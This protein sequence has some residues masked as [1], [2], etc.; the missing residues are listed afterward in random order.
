M[1]KRIVKI[2]AGAFI[3]LALLTLVAYVATGPQDP[4]AD[5]SSADWLQAGPFRIASR[6]YRFVDESRPTAENRGVPSQP[7]RTLITTLWYPE[8][9]P[10]EMPLVVHSHGILSERTELDYLAES[11]AS[12]GYVV[13][14]ANYP[15]T[16]GEAVGG[17]NAVDVVN[18]PAD[19]SF[20]MDSIL[21]LEGND[22]PFEGTIDPNKIGLTGY[23]LG[24]LTT[25]LATYHQRWREPRVSAA[26]AIAAPS[27]AF[28]PDF[29]SNSDVPMLAVAG[30]ADAVI[31]YRYNAADLPQR[32][33]KL[34]LV[35]IEGGTHLG[36]ARIAEPYMRWM[37]NPDNLACAALLETVD[38]E[39]EEIVNILGT[40][41]EGIEADRE[42]P[43]ICDYGIPKGIHPGRQQM[44][45]QI[46]TVS[47]LE[48]IFNSDLHKREDAHHQLSTVLA[49]DFAEV[50]YAD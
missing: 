19:I 13:A 31:E 22:K 32:A 21:A 15:L 26:V 33:P 42:I 34:N 41:A 24:G 8:N 46:A 47:F 20:L 18:Q 14:A 25:F 7:S 1:I 28:S 50:T 27:A 2:L 49:N 44:I 36:F 35:T 10:N 23:S 17:A 48:S 6:D 40:K 9:G 43:T 11:L 16:S 30:T 45:A 38:E 4:A 39:P 12:R 5:S 29:F 3:T 37:E